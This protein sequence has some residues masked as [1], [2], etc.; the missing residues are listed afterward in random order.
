MISR[1]LLKATIRKNRSLFI[2]FFSV[3]TLYM[4][5]MIAMYDPH[6]MEAITAML[7]L[8]PEQ[9]MSAMGFS[10]MIT[11]VNSYLASWLYGL[12][13]LG[14]PLVYCVL[15]G[16]RLVVK[17]VDDSSFAYLLSSPNSRSTIILTQGLYAMISVAVLFAGLFGLGVLACSVAF[18]GLLDVQGFFMLNVTTMLVNMVVMMICFF[19]S[20][21]FND[22]ERATAFGAGIPIAFLLMN[23]LG[24]VTAEAEIL[25]DLSIFGW[26]DPISVAAGDTAAGVDLLYLAAAVLLFAAAIQVFRRKRLPL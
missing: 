3:L 19:F 18:P 2:L 10:N 1:P 6:D 25:K 5:I 14:F 11:D 8:F 13:M 20:C 26:Y 4:T 12:L 15:L 7:D 16:N 23:I 21:L 24:G 22:T 17:M 9:M